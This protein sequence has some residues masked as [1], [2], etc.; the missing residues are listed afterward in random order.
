MERRVAVRM[1]SEWLCAGDGA[2]ELE[3]HARTFLEGVGASEIRARAEPDGLYVEAVFPA[4]LN[5]AGLARALA[6]MLYL[7]TRPKAG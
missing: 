2:G 6:P 7:L 4:R 1:R 3:G 5:T